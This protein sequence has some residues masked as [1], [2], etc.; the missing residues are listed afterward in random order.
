MSEEKGYRGGDSERTSSVW[1][2]STVA[3][4][5]LLVQ[6]LLAIVGHV[7]ESELVERLSGGDDEKGVYAL[8]VL[9]NRDRLGPERAAQIEG[10]VA[11]SNPLLREWVFTTNFSRILRPLDQSR[12][13]RQLGDSVSDKRARFFFD[14]GIHKTPWLT[15]AELD[16]YVAELDE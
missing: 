4:G 3:L 7:P 8:F 14:H 9:T 2:W 15:L 10:L 13:L 12:Y 6:I 16:E 1:R 11:S 5:I